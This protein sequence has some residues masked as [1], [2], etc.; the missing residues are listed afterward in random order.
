[1]ARLEIEIKNK[2]V[3]SVFLITN[4]SDDI[5][6]SFK[7]AYYCPNSPIRAVCMEPNEYLLMRKAQFYQRYDDK[8]IRSYQDKQDTF[9]GRVLIFTV[10]LFVG[11]GLYYL[12]GH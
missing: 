10:G 11:G 8:N 2:E 6:L 9:T 3:D 1:M 7:D 12:L 5:D 4:S